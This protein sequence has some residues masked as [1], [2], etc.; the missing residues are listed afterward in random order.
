MGRVENA[1]VIQK[2]LRKNPK[3]KKKVQSAW[4]RNKK[5]N[6]LEIIRAF[7]GW[8]LGKRVHQTS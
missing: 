4:S 3:E 7:Q 2:G 6:S 5:E 1:D 8:N